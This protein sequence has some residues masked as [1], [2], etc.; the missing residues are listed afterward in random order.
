MGRMVL[1]FHDW[2]EQKPDDDNEVIALFLFSLLAEEDRRSGLRPNHNQTFW[3]EVRLS[4]DLASR[5]RWPQLSKNEKLQA[6]F[7]FAE[8]RIQEAGRKL[9]QAPMFWTPESRLEA[10]PP[11]DISRVPFPRPSA[12]AFEVEPGAFAQR[13]ESRKAAGLKSYGE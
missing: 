6:M 3:T 12:V 5:G 10:G 11:W 4:R 7:R 8:E 1:E 2:Q 13:L 9:R